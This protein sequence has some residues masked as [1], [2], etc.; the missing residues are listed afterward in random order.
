MFELHAYHNIKGMMV[1]VQYGPIEDELMMNDGMRH[2]SE[3]MRWHR[4][5][6]EH[7]D[8]IWLRVGYLRR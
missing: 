8:M 4:Y 6:H 3:K 2:E 7:I 5:R 1:S